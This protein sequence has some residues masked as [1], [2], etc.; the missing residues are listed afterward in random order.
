MRHNSER[1]EGKNYRKFGDKPLFR[2]I[3]D[4]VLQID[5]IDQ[6]LINTD[7]QIIHD[8]IK[9]LGSEKVKAIQRPKNMLDGDIPMNKI[10]ELDLN[11]IKNN[12]IFQTHST[13]PLLKKGTIE[14]AISKF[15]ENNDNDSLFSVSKKYCRFYS[16][17]GVSI[18]HNPNKLLRTQDLEP[19][20]EENSCIYLFTKKSFLECGNRIGNNPIFFNISDIESVDIDTEIDF[21]VAEKIYE[22]I[23]K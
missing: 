5:L 13:N 14:R 17:D 7:S 1:V 23:K 22:N 21:L 3:L 18:N 15:L 9:D 10:I 11:S 19:L 12:Y 16:V 4:E 2:H 8:Q 20:L 6:V